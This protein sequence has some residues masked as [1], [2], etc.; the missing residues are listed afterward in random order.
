MNQCV[1][2]TVAVC[3]AG[4]P[5]LLPDTLPQWQKFVEEY[6]ADVFIHAWQTSDH[7][8]GR[9]RTQLLSTLNP[10]Q[11]IIEPQ[12]EFNIDLYGD[13]GRIWPYRSSPTTISSMWYSIS[14]S[15]KLSEDWSQHTGKPYD[16][17]CRARFD[18]WC[19]HIV[20]EQRPG[21]TVP[22]DPGL[23]G[24]RFTYRGQYFIAH[25]DQFGYGSA[26]VMHEYS[27]TLQ[28]IPMLFIEDGVDFCSELFLTANMIKQNIPVTYQTDMN[29]RISR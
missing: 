19:E 13:K 7:T 12:R 6:D 5:R 25:N 22:D 9:M 24:H 11:L 28:R 15:I 20:L 21:L 23:R 29:Y 17:V 27:L 18:W 1:K 8:N 3:F 2:P 10:K 26:D 4:I 16:I 14:Q